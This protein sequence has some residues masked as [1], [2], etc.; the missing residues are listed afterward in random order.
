MIQ[1]RA[2]MFV[3]K[4]SVIAF[5]LAL[6]IFGSSMRD[7]A[8]VL[9]TTVSYSAIASIVKSTAFPLALMGFAILAG[10][11]LV[12]GARIRLN[13]SGTAAFLLAFQIQL[14]IH[15]AVTGE[16]ESRLIA[17]LVLQLTLFILFFLIIPSVCR[18]RDWLMEGLK[19]VILACG[20]FT[21]LNI[22]E[23]IIN[24][25]GAS[26]KGRFLGVTTHPNFLGVA[27]AHCSVLFFSVWA[28]RRLNRVPRMLA[29]AGGFL[30]AVL[31]ATSGS[32]TGL[33][34][35]FFGFMALIFIV[36]VK[37]FARTAILL[38]PFLIAGIYL[39]I[40][41]TSSST[42]IAV[43]RVISTQDTRGAT[44]LELL[45]VFISNPL[46]GVGYDTVG[47]ASSYLRALASSGIVGSI[48][49]V[50]ALCGLT[51]LWFRTVIG[52][53]LYVYDVRFAILPLLVVTLIAAVTEGFLLDL[54][55]MPLI[56]FYVEIFGI[57]HLHR[58]LR[59]DFPKRIHSVQRYGHALVIRH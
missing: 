22:N 24:S 39:Y 11:F 53:R 10:L 3:G 58:R 27:A 55:T 9:A 37:R 19:G 2:G 28:D 26:W 21:L 43:G 50:I 51:I 5:S 54:F 35:M 13:K 4:I 6:I 57:A 30:A 47:T 42:D 17:G 23:L 56:I 7:D 52:V 29:F 32:R 49:F 40:A 25:S 14:I 59:F 46:L 34:S 45:D 33:L 38:T 41:H 36:G 16:F 20:M 12:S 31:V 18:N 48:P 44:W 15:T 8:T 1:K